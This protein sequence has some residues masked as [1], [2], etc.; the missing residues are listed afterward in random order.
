MSQATVS[1]VVAL[2]GALGAA[3]T[4]LVGWLTKKGLNYLDA[5]TRFMDEANLIQRKET[6]KNRLAEVVEIT[7]RSTMQTYV[8]ELKARNADGQLTREEAREAF[9]RTKDAALGIL[10][11]EGIQV[12]RDVLY[13][14]IEAVVGGLKAKKPGGSLGN[15]SGGGA[16]PQPA[17]A[18]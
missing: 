18:A 3:I 5:K 8:D 17:P 14:T 2:V 13:A 16:A 10:K 12:G 11:S 15:S 6:L 7:A 1:I 9:R 4:A